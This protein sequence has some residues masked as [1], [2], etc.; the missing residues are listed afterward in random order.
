MMGSPEFVV[1]MLCVL[2][3]GVAIGFGLGVTVG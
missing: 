3:V 2:A 1:W